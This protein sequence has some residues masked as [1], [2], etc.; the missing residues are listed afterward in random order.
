MGLEMF[1]ITIHHV[2]F[3]MANNIELLDRIICSWQKRSYGGASMM[4]WIHTSTI[5][6]SFREEA[7]QIFTNPL[8]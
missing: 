2:I 7:E 8:W 3:N 5:S 4:S 1:R 6:I